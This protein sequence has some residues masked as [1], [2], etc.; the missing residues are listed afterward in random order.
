MP[1][2]QIFADFYDSLTVNVEYEK[3]A[4]YIISLL[5]EKHHHKMGL[6]LDL[7]CGTGTLT[8]LLK[9]KGIDIYGVDGS[10]D[11]LSVAQQKSYEKGL[12]T[13]FLCQ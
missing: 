6:T 9:E 5:E 7:A 12:D 13:L 2:Y 1:S 11:M 8:L 10:C 3:R 4:D